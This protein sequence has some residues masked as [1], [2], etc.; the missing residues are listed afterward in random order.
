[1]TR[2]TIPTE[3]AINFGIYVND[4]LFVIRSA[5]LVDVERDD[6]KVSMDVVMLGRVDSVM[7]EIK[8]PASTIATLALSIADEK[9]AQHI[10]VATDVVGKVV[11]KGLQVA[12]DGLKDLIHGKGRDKKGPRNPNPDN[13]PPAAE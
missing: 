9:T 4:N 2:K 3:K 6:G 1:M 11:G 10:D 12:K 13:Q 7:Q 8:I 5:E